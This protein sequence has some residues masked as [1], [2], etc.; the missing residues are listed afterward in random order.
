MRG[1]DFASMEAARRLRLLSRLAEFRGFRHLPLAMASAGLHG[2]LL[3]HIAECGRASSLGLRM[4]DIWH[5]GLGLLLGTCMHEWQV[6]CRVDV[7]TVAALS[8]ACFRLPWQHDPG[9]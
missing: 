1:W 4:A 5:A 2:V 8:S 3:D 7:D 6:T 9:A